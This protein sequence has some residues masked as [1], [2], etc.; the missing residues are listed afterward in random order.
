METPAA[1][2]GALKGLLVEIRD[3]VKRVFAYSL[4]HRLRPRGLKLSVCVR[5]KAMI[6]EEYCVLAVTRKMDS[7][8]LIAERK[9]CFPGGHVDLEDHQ[10]VQGF[11]TQMEGM[12]RRAAERELLEE[13]GLKAECTM[14]YADVDECGTL[15]VMHVAYLRNAQELKAE[16]GTVRLWLPVDDFM[17]RCAWP[18]YYKRARE[19]G[20]F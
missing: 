15:C 4:L 11:M 20:A 8:L 2:Y 7:H 6:H 3:P 16:D 1:D 14:T 12:L 17:K 19:K 10:P 5:V 9:V 13:T 18:A